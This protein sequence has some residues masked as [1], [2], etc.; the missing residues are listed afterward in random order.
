M[1][2]ILIFRSVVEALSAGFEIESAYP[3]SEGFLHARIRTP[4]GWAAALVTFEPHQ[5]R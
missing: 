5:G 2:G 1:S 4:R 3:D